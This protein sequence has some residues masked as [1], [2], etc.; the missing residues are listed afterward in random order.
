LGATALVLPL[1]AEDPM[2]K[3]QVEVTNHKGEPID[4]AS[5]VVQFIENGSLKRLGKNKARKWEL[6]TNQQGIVKMPPLPQGKI[7]VQVIADRYQT[8]GEFVEI[9]EE[10]KTVQ[11]ELNPPQ[12]QYSAH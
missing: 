3:I 2:T 1:L 10:E 6:K 12:P 5:V 4:R 7:R 11:V 8:Y 9:F